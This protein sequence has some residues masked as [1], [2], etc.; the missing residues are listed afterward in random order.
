MRNNVWEYIKSD[1]YRYYGGGNNLSI[2]LHGIVPINHCFSFLFWFRLA[3]HSNIF[4]CIAK[5]IHSLNMVHW[6]IYIPAG[7]KIGYGFYIGHGVGMVINSRTI[8]GD[9]C[10]VSQF[11]SIGTNNNTPAVIGNNV[12]IGPH[13]SIVEDVT[14][15]DNA[16]IG[17]GAVITKSVP[18]N[19]TVVGVP[20]RVISF[21]NPGRYIH[22]K[23]ILK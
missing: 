2:L 18:K 3:S 5:F 23:Y 11:L 14:I 8:I 15:E 19:A 4:K 17:A 10:N 16:T 22:N 6:N 9:N 7:T 21:D 1:H 12:Y 20:G 13:V